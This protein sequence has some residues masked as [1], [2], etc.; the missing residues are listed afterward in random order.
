MFGENPNKSGNGIT[1]FR[2]DGRW[3]IAFKGQVEF[4]HE[5]NDGHV[6]SLVGRSLLKFHDDEIQRRRKQLNDW[7]Q[8]W[9]SYTLNLFTLAELHAAI[10]R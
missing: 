8:A 4:F 1:V 10:L 7:K 6:H 2:E 3:R 5:L 9:S